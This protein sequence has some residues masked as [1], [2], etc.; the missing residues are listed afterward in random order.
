MLARFLVMTVPL[1]L[2]APLAGAQTPG[3][4]GR[5]VTTAE[6]QKAVELLERSQQQL[7]DLV[8]PLTD[9]QWAFKPGQDR[10]SAGEVAE[11]LMITEESLFRLIQQMLMQ[12]ADPN[13][14]GALTKT[15][16]LERS[17]PDRSNKVQ[18]PEIL[19]PTGNVPKAQVL[20]RFKAA[21]AR[22]LKFATE[23]TAPLALHTFENPFFGKLNAYQWL[24][25]LPLHNLRH[26]QQ[27][28]EVKTSSGFP[29]R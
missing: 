25:Y 7:L 26:N 18:A 20:G 29:A 1:F 16:V 10:W 22:T 12:P 13:W 24:L 17:L 11:H 8:E 4:G 19:V 23:T 14:E 27:I 2:L 15:E 6:R 28:V 5:S 21:R 3:A 9:A